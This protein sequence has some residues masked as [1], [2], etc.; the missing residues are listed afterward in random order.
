MNKNILIY[1]FWIPRGIIAQTLFEF[2][3]QYKILYTS[4]ERGLKTLESQI[5]KTRPTYILGLGYFRRGVKHIRSEQ[6]FRDLYGRRI[7]HDKGKESY[8]SN[9]KLEIEGIKEGLNAGTSNCN[10]YG[11]K[12]LQ[13]ME[14]QELMDTRFAY[15]HVPPDFSQILFSQILLQILRSI[16][17]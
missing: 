9:W 7:I 14:E 11:Y 16:D 17:V 10:K 15:L 2:K 4:G 1:T 5:S 3:D 8:F 6:V 12:T 13:I